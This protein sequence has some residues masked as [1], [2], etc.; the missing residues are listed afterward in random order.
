[1]VPFDRMLLCLKQ[2]TDSCTT[3]TGLFAPRVGQ[4]YRD[5]QRR[6]RSQY[7]RGTTAAEM[8][9]Y[10]QSMEEYSQYDTHR[11]ARTETHTET[12][13]DAR[14]DI[15]PNVRPNGHPE[16]YVYGSFDSAHPDPIRGQPFFYSLHGDPPTSDMEPS[17][18]PR[19]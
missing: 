11:I 17:Y 4:H 9:N 12:R 18:G 8:E 5:E 14:P 3:T 15:H 13:T 7:D 6:R 1:M 2:R 19:Y 10:I 16:A